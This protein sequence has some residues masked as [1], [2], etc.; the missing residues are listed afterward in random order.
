MRMQE[1][2]DNTKETLFV[3][4]FVGR[5]DALSIIHEA[6]T[7]ST[8]KYVITF[9]GHGGIGKT[10][11]LRR[12]YSKY[13]GN[14]DIVILRIDY[15]DSSFQSIP[16][17]ATN[18]VTQLLAQGVIEH[19]GLQRFQDNIEAVRVAFSENADESL[20]EEME[21]KAYGDLISQINSRLAGRRMLIISDSADVSITD[22]M[23]DS[24][25]VNVIASDFENTVIIMAARP[26]EYIRRIL[27]HDYPNVY[28]AKNWRVREEHL[29]VFSVDEAF[30][31]FTRVLP[32][33]I[34]RNL[35]EKLVIL[36]DGKPVL[37]ALVTAWLTHNVQLPREIDMSVDEL[38]SLPSLEL[39]QLR[40]YF[41]RA[42]VQR[43]R[44]VREPLDRAI[45]FLSYLDRRYDKR[46]LQIALDMTAEEVEELEPAL[47]RMPF[48]R[49]FMGEASG[50]LHDE[51]KHLII[52]HAWP[53]YDPDSKVREML[54]RNAVE[55]FYLPEIEE[56][57]IQALGDTSHRIAFQSPSDYKIYQLQME[58]IDY[59]FRI[60]LD[61]GRRYLT[62]LILEGV[63]LPKREGLR[64]EIANRVGEDESRVALA[65]MNLACG[66]YEGNHETIEQVLKQ[67]DI[68]LWYKMTLLRELSDVPADPEE[69]AT[70]LRHAMEIAEE[71]QDQISVAHITNDLGLMYRK[72]GLWA[73]A[74]D[75]YNQAL[76]ILRTLDEENQRAATLNNLAYVKLLQGEFDLAAGL[77]D[78]A[79]K[80]RKSQGNQLG[81]AFSYLT[82]GEIAETM[83]LPIQALQS[84]QT[85]ATLFEKLGRDQN[86]AQVLIRL[87]E[88]KR[89]E[90]D[91]TA[92]RELLAAGLMQPLSETRAQAERELGALYRSQGILAES[93]K[94]KTEWFNKAIGEFRKSLE[95]SRHNRDWHGQAEAL[96]DLTFMDFI[97]DGKINDEN[98]TLLRNILAERDYPVLKAEL[99]EIH[100]DILYT[101]GEV[102]KAFEMYTQVAKVLSTHHIRK[103]HAMFERFKRRFLEQTRS[104]QNNLCS[105]FEQ[106]IA[107]LPQE[108]RL[109][110]S[111]S[112]LCLAIKIAT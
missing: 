1:Q 100:A 95:T 50:L 86:Y 30:E 48:I 41:E 103:Y 91:F 89:H 96:Y 15:S 69:K 32:A 68:S 93:S 57:S 3:D 16:A 19:D 13:Q 37:L 63:S 54:A 23:E 90:N 51:A 82:K 97:V 8:N 98:I 40:R 108:S 42:L 52:E 36:T 17:I 35:V 61:Q 60:S 29:S 25:R 44:V 74:E 12:V 80:M 55:C 83:D 6:V 84:Y 76:T 59:S 18:L 110:S 87:A 38:R 20:I 21:R 24:S 75:A 112:N 72:Q 7:D 102:K 47:M 81:V 31:Y 77:V 56:L 107:E 111:L 39:Q 85:A 49:A 26:T 67:E 33:P 104:E 34:D 92:A 27:D 45:L 22:A 66:R 5:E 106:I 28:Q 53:P 2:L 64:S 70:Y 4:K 109:R 88:V 14:N 10:A 58:C 94:E 71:I 65:R 78:Y 62:Q 99:D 11:L 101:D 105:Y 46:I 79:L 9:L 43:V 73:Q